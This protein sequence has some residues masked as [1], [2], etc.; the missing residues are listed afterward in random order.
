MQGWNE[1]SSQGS[2][3]GASGVESE[4]QRVKKPSSWEG[5]MVIYWRADKD[6]CRGGRWLPRQAGAT[7]VLERASHGQ[8][9]PQEEVWHREMVLICSMVCFRSRLSATHQSVKTAGSCGHCR[10]YLQDSNPCGSIEA[11]SNGKRAL[12]LELFPMPSFHRACAV[13]THGMALQQS[14]WRDDIEMDA[15]NA[16][17]PWRWVMVGS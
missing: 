8:L 10:P 14:M 7:E 11:G 16:M 13:P 6:C 3:P 4:R 17:S 9:D 2:G 1:S 5:R 12:L 15:G